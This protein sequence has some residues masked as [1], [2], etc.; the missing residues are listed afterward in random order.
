MS[1]A[2][3]VVFGVAVASSA[4][5]RSPWLTYR[6]GRVTPTTHAPSHGVLP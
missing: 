5:G 3:A 4:D 1:I 6:V 2:I